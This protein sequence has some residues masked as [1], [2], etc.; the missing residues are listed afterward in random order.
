MRKG[1]RV[2]HNGSSSR[3][4]KTLMTATP[5]RVYG[6]EIRGKRFNLMS[7]ALYLRDRKG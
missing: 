4:N 7:I 6:E 3:D 5:Y 2:P 1:D